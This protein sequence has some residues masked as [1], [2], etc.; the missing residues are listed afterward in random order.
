MSTVLN[1]LAQTLAN[2][3]LSFKERNPNADRSELAEFLIGKRELLDSSNLTDLEKT[4][5]LW[6]ALEL[7]GN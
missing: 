7:S 5:V 4:E 6:E 3:I 2:D 1:E